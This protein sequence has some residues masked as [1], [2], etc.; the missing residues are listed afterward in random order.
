MR[1]VILV[2]G[3]IFMGVMLVQSI[4]VGIAGDDLGVPEFTR[5]GAI[6]RLA[7]IMLGI[8]SAF[9]LTKP[10]TSI[11]IFAA[12]GGVSIL[13]AMPTGFQD[14]LLWGIA[15]LILAFMSYLSWREIE[16]LSTFI[17]WIKTKVDR[18]KSKL[19]R[20]KESPEESEF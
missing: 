6:G 10:Y 9:V 1:I 15:A 18:V 2:L 14:L 5:G 8:G 11:F 16:D 7:A 4:Y 19:K 3:V 12:V 17:D 13:S 20:D